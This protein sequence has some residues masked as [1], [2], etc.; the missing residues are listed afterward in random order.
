VG[1]IGSDTKLQH[2]IIGDSVNRTAR[3][4]GLCKDLQASLLVSEEVW[5]SVSN[6]KFPEFKSFGKKTIRGIK[7]P[8]GVY[9]IPR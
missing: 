4:E 6:A 2:T 7:D 1:L 5:S 9:G 8:I 3:L